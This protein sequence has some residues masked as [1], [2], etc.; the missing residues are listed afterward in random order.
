MN[1]GVSQKVLI[2]ADIHLTDNQLSSIYIYTYSHLNTDGLPQN[3]HNP[4]TK[5]TNY[6]TYYIKALII[7]VLVELKKTRGIVINYC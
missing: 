4:G 2:A 6:A 7:L 5:Y 3:R 1:D